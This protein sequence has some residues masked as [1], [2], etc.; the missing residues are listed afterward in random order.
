MNLCFDGKMFGNVATWLLVKERMRYQMI[1]NVATWP[2]VKERYY[3]ALWHLTVGQGKILNGTWL[4][5]KGCIK[6]FDLSKICGNKWIFCVNFEERSLLR[7]IYKFMKLWIQISRMFEEILG[8]ILVACF[9]V[10]NHLY[11]VVLIN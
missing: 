5:V 8:K 6:C 2:L 7:R 3:M 9:L 4:R 11:E 10:I 1:G